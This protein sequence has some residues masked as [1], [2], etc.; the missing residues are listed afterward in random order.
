MAVGIALVSLLALAGA[1]GGTFYERLN[2][3]VV[4]ERHYPPHNAVLQKLLY[5]PPPR[6]DSVSRQESDP[7]LGQRVRPVS[8]DL[9]QEKSNGGRPR[10]TSQPLYT[11][12]VGDTYRYEIQAQTPGVN[13]GEITYSLVSGPAKMTIDEA[14]GQLTWTPSSSDGGEKTVSVAAYG[15]G[16]KGMEQTFDLYVSETPHFFGT[17]WRGRGMGASMLLG[18]RW[19]LLP[20]CI[21]V[22]VAMLLGTLVG[23][24]AGYYEGVVERILTYISSVTEA[25]PS[26]VLLFLAAVIFQ[27]NIFLIMIVVGIILFP[28]VAT[29]VKSKVQSLK[30][31]QFVEASRELGLRDRV[32]LWRDIV[33][34]NA[35]PELLLQA[36]RAFVFAIIV[37][38]T[39][40]YLNL[41]IQVPEVSWGNL[42][43][44]GR[45][46]LIN[47]MYWPVVL[48]GIAIVI[49]VAAFYL[50]ADGV[51]R[52]YE[53][54]TS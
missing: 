47:G 46:Q 28:R 9:T 11:A 36:S 27:Y 25:V 7:L 20:G 6:R 39:L 30:S 53:P 31:R 13:R 40:S 51:R 1:I 37:E 42:L 33:W 34:F 35:R 3:E 8:E 15:P 26:L 38:V 19:V 17:D 10:V 48:P 45:G 50:L 49:A 43:S 5:H 12:V 44:Q 23:G 2:E 18:A 54:G 52:R 16:G 21:A 29:A 14:T 41:G 4:A 24:I 22:L 32:I